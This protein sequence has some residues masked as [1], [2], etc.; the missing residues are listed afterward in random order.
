MITF[1]DL[2]KL[3]MFQLKQIA[4]DLNVGQNC[5]TKEDFARKIMNSMAINA[6]REGLSDT[7]IHF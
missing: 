6:L 5:K 2:M 1:Q 3:Q 7:F 4:D